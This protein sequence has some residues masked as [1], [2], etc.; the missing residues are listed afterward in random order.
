M[1]DRQMVQLKLLGNMKN[2][3]VIGQVKK[4]QVFMML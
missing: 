1:A 4:T 3:L 2:I